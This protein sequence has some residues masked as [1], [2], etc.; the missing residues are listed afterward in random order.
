MHKHD[1][2]MGNLNVKNKEELIKMILEIKNEGTLEYLH[3]FVKLF[4]EK[5]G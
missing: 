2:I 5:W 1:E 3:E 4:L